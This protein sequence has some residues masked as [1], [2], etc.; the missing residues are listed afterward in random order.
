MEEDKDFANESFTKDEL[1]ENV[2]E[3][4]NRKS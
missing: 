1:R 3:Y 4:N 2:I